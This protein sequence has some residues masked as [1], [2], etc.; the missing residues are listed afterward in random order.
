MPSA[1]RKSLI[2][3]YTFSSDPLTSQPRL[4]SS[5]ASV[6]IAVPQTPMRWIRLLR[7]NGRFLDND[8]G[9]GRRD[10]PD[11][12]AERQGPAGPGRMTGG[13][14]KEHGTREMSHHRVQGA[15]GGHAAPRLV[16]AAHLSEDDCA[17]P[18]Q[19]AA[20]A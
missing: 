8:R 5:A 2:G 19:H 9:P 16:A 18:A 15:R 12:H 4:R 20:Q 6:A 3:G 13:K 14:S 17:R 1:A 10:H 11:L 7:L